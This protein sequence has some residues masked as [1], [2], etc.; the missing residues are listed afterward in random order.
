MSLFEEEFRLWGG[1]KGAA[2]HAGR[3]YRE[4]SNE[5]IL[6]RK[7]SPKYLSTTEEKRKRL[8]HR[9]NEKKRLVTVDVACANR[10][11][12]ALE[13]E[14]APLH[15]EMQFTNPEERRKGRNP[16]RRRNLGRQ[17]SRNL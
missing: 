14:R 9:G 13:V 4:D 3:H 7:G 16:T 5:S 17:I 8:L 15:S 6:A 1:G 11:C 12:P 10:P 2:P